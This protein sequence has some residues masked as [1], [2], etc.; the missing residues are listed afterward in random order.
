[1]AVVIIV[2]FFNDQ[3]LEDLI[4]WSNG[5]FVIIYLLA[6]LSAARL[7]S[8]RYLPLVIA[9]CFFCIG[10]GIALG[11]NMIYAVGLVM[12]VAPFMWWQK[13]HLT[14]KYSLINVRE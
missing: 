4:G 14:R 7:L 11:S 13:L 3:E 12:I 9:G 8:K 10:L 6:M 5:V 2:V 1:M